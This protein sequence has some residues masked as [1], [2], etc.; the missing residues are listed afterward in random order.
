MPFVILLLYWICTNKG[1]LL[2]YTHLFDA[3]IFYAF[4]GY[5]PLF[6][7]LSSV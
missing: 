6:L 3:L 4:N 1:K 5:M 7:F 2:F